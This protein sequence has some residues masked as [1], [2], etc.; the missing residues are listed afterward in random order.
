MLAKNLNTK[1][2]EIIRKAPSS[3]LQIKEETR[4]TKRNEKEDPLRDL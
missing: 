2:I 4:W 1:L 3:Y